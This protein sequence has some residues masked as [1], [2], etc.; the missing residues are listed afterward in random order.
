MSTAIASSFSLSG[1]RADFPMLKRKIDGMPLVYLDSAA[2]TLKPQSVIDAVM[3]YY[4]QSTANIHRGRHILSEEASDSYEETRYRIAVLAG[5][6]S[7]EVVFVRNT[8]EALNLA[9][10]LLG[11]DNKDLVI[12]FLDAH[13]SQVLPW[14]HRANFQRVRQTP[15]FQPDLDHYASLLSMGPKAVVV[16]H[17][18]NVTGTIVPLDEI[19]RMAKQAGAAVVV[20]A[21][22]SIAH[23]RLN[24]GKLD[25]DF[26]AFSS[27]KMYGPSGIGCLIGKASRLQD[28]QPLHFGGGMVDYVTDTSWQLR[29]IPHRFEA[30]TPAIEAS[31]GLRAA[32][33][34]IEGLGFAAVQAHEAALTQTLVTEIRNRSYLRMLG[35]YGTEHRVPT[36][37]FW[38]DGLPNL[39]DVT[40]SL[41][42]SYGIMCRNG[43]LCAQ[44]L[45][46]AY[47]DG[48]VLR[49]SAAIYSAPAEISTA[50]EALDAI[51]S[52][53]G[54]R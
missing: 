7:N 45:V 33:D 23:Q 17:G 15:A 28:A 24:F 40:R 48:E 21:A 50:F 3:K 22:Q 18:S 44:P 5:C 49:V 51:V 47:T 39:S 29:K 6:A 11:L 12:G 25:I 30:G 4:L 31:Y 53:Y 36:A 42:D 27:H 10:Q 52:A 35:G 8:T 43:H 26:L 20:D 41:S 38:I 37:S 9:S 2:T 46:D 1:V 16:T 13:H 32:V 34:Y 54:V 19:V 14:M